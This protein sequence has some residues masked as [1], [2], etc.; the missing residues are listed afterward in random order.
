MEAAAEPGRWV[1]A[2]AEYQRGIMNAFSDTTVHTIV[3]PKA[4]QVGFTECV[5]NALGFIVHQDP[6]PILILQPTIDAG[7]TWS[8]ERLAPM[9][10]DTPVLRGLVRQPISRYVENSL[11]FKSF[12][13]GYMAIVGS[14]A[15]AGLAA[16]PIRVVFADEVDRFKTS[17]GT[18]GDPLQLAA[19]RQTTFWN[20]K[21][22]LGSS[23]GR[24]ATS[25]IWREWLKSD[26]RRFYVPCPQCEEKQTL[27]WENVRWDKAADSEQRRVGA[28]FWPHKPETAYYVCEHCGNPWDD[29]VR[30]EAVSKG[31]WR[32]TAPFNGIAGFHIPGFISPWLTLT[33]IVVEFLKAKDVPELLQVWVNTVLGEPFEDPAETVESSSLVSRGEQYGPEL[34]PEGVKLL[35]AGVDVQGDRLECQVLGFGPREE[36]WAIEYHV[37]PGD[38]AQQHLWMELDEQ[39]LKVYP[40]EDERQLRIRAVCIDTGGHHGNQVLAFCKGRRGR[41]VLPIKG[42]S[43]ARPIWPKRESKAKKDFYVVGVD[44]AKDA[45][46]GRLRI[47]KPGPGYIHFPVGVDFNEQ[48]FQQ[49]TCEKV[50]TR[51][52]LGHPVRVWEKP[53]GAKNEALDTFVYALA[54]R[55]AL[56][57]RFEPVPIPIAPAP[58]AGRP[59]EPPPPKSLFGPPPPPMPAEHEAE[60]VRERSPPGGP[61]PNPGITPRPW[62][63]QLRGRR[64]LRSTYMS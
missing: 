63:P 48:Y 55:Q 3:V 29:V 36:C 22:L 49:L 59:A 31:E 51:Y 44:T 57:I 28:P 40:T 32:A 23:P 19:K 42:A 21:T 56:P 52:R 35:V 54:A 6:C 50:M 8:K 2:R 30:W 18:E 13:G 20:R 9:V 64:I 45:I 47:A 17:A 46:Y 15:P 43:G 1:T 27:R 34:I 16:R 12:P 60:S 33:D 38:P 14:N 25:V 53:P 7:E 58:V 41:K 26:Q 11:R 37:L 61:P 4:A 10:R 5:L 39:L 62:R 24:K